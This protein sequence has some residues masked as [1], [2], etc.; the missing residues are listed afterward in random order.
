[1][2]ALIVDGHTMSLIAHL[3]R[4]T[5]IKPVFFADQWLTRAQ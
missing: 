3:L 4:A 2:C 1:M 5:L